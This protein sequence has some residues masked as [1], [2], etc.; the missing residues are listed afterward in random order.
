MSQVGAPKRFTVVQYERM[1][2]T[3]ILHEDDRVELIRG[4][5]VQM[6]AL[7]SKHVGCVNRGTA[8]FSRQCAGHAIVS[9]QNPVRLGAD[10][11]PQPDI[12]LLRLRS[13]FYGDAHPG[14]EDVFLIVE[15]ADSS[16]GYDRR[17]KLPLYAENGIPELW[18]VDVDHE[19]IELYRQPEAGHYRQVEVKY[20]GD[21]LV[22]QMLPVIAIPVT[23]ILG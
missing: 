15:V 5:I 21:V 12:M 14:P 4:E 9:V 1:G 8:E 20:R 22:P 6:A 7:G 18:I 11:E 13:D 16:L 3:G 17:V 2:Q 19:L 23:A 10:S